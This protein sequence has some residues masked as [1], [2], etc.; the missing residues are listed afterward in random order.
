VLKGGDARE[1]LVRC[2]LGNLNTLA[3][4]NSMKKYGCIF[5]AAVFV[6]G[7]LMVTTN[8]QATEVEVPKIQL[9]GLIEVGG[10]WQDIDYKGANPPDEEEDNS[11]LCLTTVELTAEAEINEWVNVVATLL[12]EDFTP[13]GFEDR[14]TDVEIDEAMVTIGNTEEFPVYCSAG[15]MYVPFGALLTNFPDDPLINAPLTLL[16]GETLEKALLVG[17]KH[18]GFSVSAYAFN[19]DMDER[20]EENNV[21][22]Y[23][24]DA[25]YSMDDETGFDLLVGASY[26][27]NL[28]D[29]D[30]VTELLEENDIDAV[31][32]YIAGFAAYLHV[33]YADFFV[34]A[35]YMTALDDIEEKDY[36]GVGLPAGFEAQP[37]VWNVEVGYNYDW[38][39]NLQIVLK[40]AGSN[41]AELGELPETRY[42]ICL[43]QELFEDVI[44]SLGYLYDDFDDED[45]FI[46]DIEDDRDL[47]F[48][49]IAIEF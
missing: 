25:N 41:E 38:G 19:G 47:L 35:E 40:Y 4:R 22:S 12:Y 48:A 11:D 29:S 16:L 34:D 31:E 7:L 32:D 3:R 27:S 2:I 24:V 14:E 28:A 45:D 6:L 49:Q 39:K 44:L 15:K 42:G 36:P 37:A 8:A 13:F 1:V 26:I 20:H 46:G 33:G 43:N 23:G 10:G 9:S 18:E 5:F 30:G 17:V 21:E